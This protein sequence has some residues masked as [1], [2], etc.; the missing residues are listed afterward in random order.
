VSVS[1][2]GIGTPRET[3]RQEGDR[4]T[5]AL[6]SVRVR[7]PLAAPRGSVARGRQADATKKRQRGTDGI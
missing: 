5:V 6:R 2:A 4:R 3:R 1:V 7:F